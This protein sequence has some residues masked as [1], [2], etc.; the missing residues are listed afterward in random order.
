M[1]M[2]QYSCTTIQ[3][4]LYSRTNTVVPMYL[5]YSGCGTDEP[6]AI[7]RVSIYLCLPDV[8]ALP[9]ASRVIN[10]GRPNGGGTLTLV[11]GGK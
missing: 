1:N 9:A 11:S 3:S 7:L 10:H 4:Y 6:T 8:T 2:S 5:P